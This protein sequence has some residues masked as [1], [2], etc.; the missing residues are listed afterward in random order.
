M[1]VRDGQLALIERKRHGRRYWVIPGGG[2]EPGE[3]A[4]EAAVRE[5]NEELGVP[6]VL[7]ELRV[8]IDHREQDGSIQRHWYF[9]AS[10]GSNAI[11]FNGAEA[12][13]PGNGTYRA[14]WV[15][16]D[17]VEPSSV[18]PAA[19]AQAVV[20]NRGQWPSHVIEIDEG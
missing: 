9:D 11:S 14:V 16:L 4:A 6:A 13:R 20:D 3:S 10:V 19:V 12:L 2:I 5:A 17:L 15:A 1:I 7:G 18:L 8:R